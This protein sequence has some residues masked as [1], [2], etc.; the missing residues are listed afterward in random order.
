MVELEESKVKDTNKN[1]Y[2]YIQALCEKV[3]EALDNG[4]NSV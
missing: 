4:A 1:I 2:I 3:R